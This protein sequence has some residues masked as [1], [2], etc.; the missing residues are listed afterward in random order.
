M[1][2]KKIY[3]CLIIGA[4]P[5]GLTAAIYAQRAGLKCLIIEKDTPGGKMSKTA[6]IE[7]YPGF[8]SIKGF[9]I[10]L[11]MLNQ[12]KETGVTYLY[13]DVTSI[14]KKENIFELKI[15]DDQSIFGKTV[16][17]A[18]GMKERK[19]GVPGEEKFYGNGVSYCAICDGVLYRNKEVVVVGGG[20]SAFEESI[21]LSE[22]A[23]KVYLIHR[24]DKFRA[25]QKIIDKVKSISKIELIT[26]TILK[27]INGEKQVTSVTVHHVLNK[28][29]KDIKIDGVFIFI[30]YNPETSFIDKNIIDINEN[31]I[32]TNEDMET[33]T[34]G[35]FSIGDVNK[36]KFRQIS[37][38]VS[39]GTI[40][41][42]NVKKYIENKF[43]N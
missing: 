18:T 31:F 20:N 7:N 11:N 12:A 41:A 9:E 32:V 26:N 39:D 10:S 23:S 21:Y 19:V 24:T 8:K 2:N 29:D 35:L 15:L 33:R 25:E 36:K 30:G 4:G 37:T 38:A 43:E 17:I 6:I 22:L 42:L 5:A 40:A 16:I 1:Q 34:P 14:I 28:T 27:S 3:D 13:G